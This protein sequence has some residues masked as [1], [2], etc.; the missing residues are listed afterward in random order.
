[1]G[2]RLA[3]LGLRTLSRCYWRGRGGVA[4]ED[5]PVGGTNYSYAAAIIPRTF[6]IPPPCAISFCPPQHCSSVSDPYLLPCQLTSVISISVLLQRAGEC[7]EVRGGAFKTKVS[8]KI[9]FMYDSWP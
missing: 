8:I 9:Y 1:M 6:C 2:S 7:M 3:S 5:V 4:L